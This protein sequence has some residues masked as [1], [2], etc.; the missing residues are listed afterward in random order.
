MAAAAASPA[1]SVQT[2]TSAASDTTA[3]SRFMGLFRGKQAASSLKSE[4]TSSSS[5]KGSRRN[6]NGADSDELSQADPLC[7][8]T[9]W[10]HPRNDDGAVGTSHLARKTGAS[11]RSGN[12][13]FAPWIPLWWWSYVDP[14]RWREINSNAALE[15]SL[16]KMLPTWM[17]INKVY[18]YIPSLKLMYKIW[19]LNYF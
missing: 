9:P 8:N 3:F 12:K 7:H 15:E 1:A 11:S 19:I 4:D 13:E 2:T 6:L 5:G 17:P 14:Y 10:R 18:L 16:F